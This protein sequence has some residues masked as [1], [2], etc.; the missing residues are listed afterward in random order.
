M[1]QKFEET[2]F[3]AVIT[4]KVMENLPKYYKIISDV[5]A[6]NLT[7]TFNNDKHAMKAMYVIVKEGV[8]WGPLQRFDWRKQYFF[9]TEKEFDKAW[10]DMYQDM[11]R[12]RIA[13]GT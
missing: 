9:Q 5:D 2:F 8:D 4:D 6:A 11:S 13:Q 10:D 7:A 3:V 12:W 1:T